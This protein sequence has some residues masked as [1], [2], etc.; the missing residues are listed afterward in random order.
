MSSTESPTSDVGIWDVLGIAPTSDE[1]EIRRAYAR[2]LKSTHPEDDADGFRQL[3]EAYEMALRGAKAQVAR[4]PRPVPTEPKSEPAS[5]VPGPS[6]APPVVVRAPD[7]T[8]IGIALANE[9]LS[10]LNTE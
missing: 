2:A 9:V 8:Q 5:S 7:E 10:A 4:R 1:R 3:R 6:E